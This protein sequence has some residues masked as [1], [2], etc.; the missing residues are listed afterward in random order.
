MYRKNSEFSSL[1]KAIQNNPP[2]NKKFQGEDNI[3]IVRFILVL[4]N[5]IKCWCLCWHPRFKED[6]EEKVTGVK[7][8]PGREVLG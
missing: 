1:D 7:W 8:R 5:N 3:E 4:K 6:A 2:N